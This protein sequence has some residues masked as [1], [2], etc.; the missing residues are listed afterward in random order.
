MDKSRGSSC[1]AL[2][3]SKRRREDSPA[4]AVDLELEASLRSKLESEQAARE[5][6]ARGRDAWASGPE[7]VQRSERDGVTGS[8]PQGSGSGPSPSPVLDPWEAAAASG[9]GVSSSSASLPTQGAGRGS[10]APSRPLPPPPP[11]AFGAGSGFRPPPRSFAGPARRPP[12]PASGAPL[13]PGMGDGILPPP[14]AHQQPRPAPASHSTPSALTCF[15]CHRPGHFQSRCTNPP[16]CL[17]CRSDGH[18]TVNCMDRQKPPAVFQFGMGLPGCSFFAFD[19]DLPVREV[20][21]A[22][23][24]AAIVS[25]KDQKISPQTLLEGLRIWDVAGWDWQVVQLS[26]FDFSVVFPSKD[27]L[28]M[29]ASCTSFTLPLNQLVVSVKAAASNGTAVGPLS[30][31]WVLIDDLPASLRSSVFLMSFGVLIGKPIEVDEESLNKVGPA[32]MKVWCV[33]PERVHGFIDVYP[34]PNGIRLRVR[35][36]GAAAAFQAPPPP[37]R[38]L[39]LRISMISMTRK[40]MVPLVALIRALGL[41]SASL[42]PNGMDWQTQNGS[43]FNLKRLVVMPLVMIR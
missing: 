25:V 14:P 26:D 43:C 42:N 37:L 27:C 7:R 9:G 39:I 11:R 16:F 35:V 1:E 2:S 29:I 28:R 10:S 17:I 18:L 6:A 21:P 32:R 38:L 23:S 33:D 20:A 12:G 31:V 24:N 36:E 34:S 15:A 8:G 4:S 30:Q 40:G 19:G 13:P 22:L 3:G 5:Q 41:I